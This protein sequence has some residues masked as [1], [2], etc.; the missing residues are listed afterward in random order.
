MRRILE[1]SRPASFCGHAGAGASHAT[2]RADRD[3][4]VADRG[5]APARALGVD[6]HCSR[7]AGPAHGGEASN[8]AVAVNLARAMEADVVT[9]VCSLLTEPA[10]NS[11]AICAGHPDLGN[12]MLTLVRL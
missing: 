8:S 6:P 3:D 2:D 1:V 9:T 12:V 4:P 11:R 5:R 10:G 7:G